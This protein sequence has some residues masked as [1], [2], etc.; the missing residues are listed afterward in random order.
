MDLNPKTRSKTS[1][2]LEEKPDKQ[3]PA[4]ETRKGR[5][6]S[7][8]DRACK[9]I[10]SEP[11]KK[12]IRSTS[13]DGKGKETKANG[14]QKRKRR[15]RGSTSL[16]GHAVSKHRQQKQTAYACEDIIIIIM[17]VIL[18]RDVGLRFL[19]HAPECVGPT[20]VGLGKVWSGSWAGPIPSWLGHVV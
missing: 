19:K 2:Q 4:V 15:L 6:T 11:E 10:W 8:G 18:E 7:W 20:C 17:S 13:K 16:C 12:L 1:K 14:V 9:G 3:K 5:S